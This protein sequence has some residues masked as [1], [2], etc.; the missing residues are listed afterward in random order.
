MRNWLRPL[1]WGPPAFTEHRNE[2]LRYAII[3]VCNLRFTHRPLSIR[4]RKSKK[5][6]YRSANFIFL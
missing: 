4:A 5:P 1:A 3:N 2:M 6:G